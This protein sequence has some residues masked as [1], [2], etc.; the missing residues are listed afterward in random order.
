MVRA[1]NIVLGIFNGILLIIGLAAICTGLYFFVGSNSQCEKGVENELLIM[2]AALVLVSLLGLIGSCYGINFF[3][4]FYLIVM[5]LLILGLICFTF[6]TIFVTNEAVGKAASRTKIMNFNSWI[7]DH[8]VNDRNWHQIRDCLVDAKVCKSLGA[9]VDPHVSDF[10]KKNLSPIQSGCCK[11]PNE[12]GFEHQNATFWL[13]PKAGAV[14]NRDCTT[15]NNQQTTLCY[16]CESCKDGVVDNI[17][18]KWQ[19]LAIANACITVLLI[20][21]YSI[22]CC[23]KRNNSAEN[24]Y[25]KYRGGYRSYP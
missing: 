18:H 19:V 20:I 21:L 4:I 2:G 8:F 16:N 13:K 9:D 14:K 3:L 1:S 5:F 6:F 15:W 12:C 24:S 22:G 17:R 25:G 7:R 11:P 23:A 10:Y